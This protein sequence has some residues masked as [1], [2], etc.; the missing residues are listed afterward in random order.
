MKYNF[1][2]I[3]INNYVMR[4]LFL[5]G[6][7]HKPMKQFN[8]SE[9]RFVTSSGKNIGWDDITILCTLLVKMWTSDHKLKY[10]SVLI[11]NYLL[12]STQLTASLNLSIML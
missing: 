12:Y 4:G 9:R 11:S 1:N 10:Y 8:H 5:P 6:N 3:L 2:V 7:V